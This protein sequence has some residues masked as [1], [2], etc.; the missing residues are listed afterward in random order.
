M[1]RVMNSPDTLP[2]MAESRS[3]RPVVDHTTADVRVANDDASS[4]NHTMPGF[5][6]T[7]NQISTAAERAF[8][9]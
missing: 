3:T 2:W 9:S 7:C 8:A 1:R 5:C 6:R 4:F